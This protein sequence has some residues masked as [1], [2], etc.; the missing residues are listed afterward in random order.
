MKIVCLDA[1]TLGDYDLSVFQTLG[2]LE[3]YAMTTKEE[4]I[5][6]LK[7]ADVAMVN[8][9]VIDKNVIDACENLKLILETATGVNNI[10]VEYAKE[11][12][13]IVKNA[14]GYSTMSVVQHTFAFIFAFLNQM[15]YYDQ[16]SKEG[17]WCNS[18][19]FTDYSRSLHTLGGKKHGI[20]GLGTIG[21]EVAKIS[22]LFGA[23]IYYYSTSGK[24]ENADFKRLELEQLLKTCDIISIHAP[25]NENTKDLLTFKEL[26]LLKD[27]VILVNVGRG[28][29]INEQDLAKI[30]DEKNIRVGLDVLEQ[31]PMMKN[32]P[33]LYL[34]NKENLIITPHVAWASKEALS[35]LMDIVYNNLKEWIENGK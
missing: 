12:N 6:R 25:L 3:V 28:G 11:K 4:V 30:M 29:I 1:A 21:K 26:K 35:A 23:E 31:E 16:W 13:I 14:S 9:I 19:I 2:S 24:N 17:K 34:K 5:Q 10:D 27:N 20:I 22:K 33:L 7:N 18:P 15:I 32:H 8:K